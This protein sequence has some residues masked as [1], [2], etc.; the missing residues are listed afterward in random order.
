MTTW[1]NCIPK[2]V[3]DKIKAS[4]QTG[5][6]WIESLDSLIDT[7]EKRWEIKVIKVLEGGTHAFIGEAM[8]PCNQR[9][10]LKLSMPEMIGETGFENEMKAL[11]LADG[12]GYVQLLQYD[13][14]CG[15]ALLEKL[16]KPLKILH[17]PVNDQIDII[18]NALRKSWVKVPKGTNLQDGKDICFFFLN[19]LD[20]LY[21][22]YSAL[23]SK[24]TMDKVMMACES[25]LDAFT[26]EKSVLVHGVS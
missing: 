21:K 3:L 16:G 25:R 17:L 4:G 26:Y 14:S 23:I 8:T 20:D 15:A 22:E 5:V 2:P 12:N 18:C 7:L 11:Q 6:E 10:I 13:V 19:F 1:I 9:V 24:E